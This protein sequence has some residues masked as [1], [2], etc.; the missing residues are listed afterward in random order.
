MVQGQED[1]VQVVYKDETIWATQVAMGELFKASK[2]A[3]LS[4][5]ASVCTTKLVS[6]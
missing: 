5:A 2:L 3:L 1:G 6:L 4:L